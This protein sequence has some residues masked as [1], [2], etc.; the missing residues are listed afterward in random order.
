MKR[1]ERNIVKQ[2]AIYITALIV[3]CVPSLASA[4]DSN[5]LWDWNFSEGQGS[6][7]RDASAGT[8]S[9]NSSGMVARADGEYRWV[10]APQGHAMEF[11][12]ITGRL[13]IE[14]E[15]YF[16]I[17]GD[18]GMT[19]H[20][21]VRVVKSGET[22][23]I[24]Y[25]APTLELELRGENGV[26]SFNLI[27]QDGGSARCLGK[28]PISDGRWHDV[29]AIRDPQTRTLRLYV[30]G[31]LE[32][33]VEDGTAGQLLAIPRGAMLG[34]KPGD[35]EMLGGA[36]AKVAMTRGVTHISPR[37]AA[38]DEKET[39]SWTLAN[40]QVEIEFVDRNGTLAIDSLIDRNTNTQFIEKSVL[41]PNNLWQ[42]SLRSAR[43]PAILDETQGELK[44][45]QT[46]TGIVFTW[47]KLPLGDGEATVTMSVELPAG[48]VMSTWKLDV[49]HDSDEFGVWTAHSP[50]ISNLRQ[51]DE[52]PMKNFVA[53]P[54][55]NGGGA[56]E[57]QLFENPWETMHPIIR[58]YPCY[59]QSMQ[60]NAWYGPD[61]GLYLGTHD[62]DMHLKGFLIKPAATQDDTP[63]MTYEVIHY[64][65]DSGVEG[66][67][68][69][70]SYPAVV[71][72]FQGDW[73]DAS[74]IYR[75]WAVDQVWC[76]LGPA[77]QRT[78]ISPWL[79]EGAWWTVFSM[80]RTDDHRPA[81]RRKAREMPLDEM[82]RQA[83]NLDIESNIKRVERAYDYFGFPMVLWCN[84]WW[85]GGGDISPPRY[86][87]MRGLTEFLTELRSRVP[88]AHLSGHMQAKRFSVQLLEYTDEVKATIE[89]TADGN[90]AIEPMDAMDKGDQIAYPCW[91]TEFWQEDWRKRTDRIASYG[92]DG[93]HMDELG[94]H[95]DFTVQ[96]FN[97][98]HGHPVGG[99]TMYA[100]TRRNMVTIIRDEARKHQPGFA[101]HHEVL[102]EIYID[103]ADAAEVCTS[104]NN[105]N[106]PMWEAV[107]HDYY[108][109]MGRRIIEW[110][111]RNTYPIGARDGD[112]L[113][114]EFASSYAQTFI[115]GNQPSWTRIDILDYAPRV[116]AFIK[117]TMN[118]RYRTLDYLNFGDMM[119]P[120]V[121][122]TPLEK[123]TR[124]WRLNDTPEHTLPVVLNS[125]WKAPD[126]SLG[127]VLFN[128]TDQPQTID[129]R[130]DLA[131]C[132]LKG[133]RFTIT[134]I[135]GE[136]PQPMGTST[137][138]ML[139]RSDTIEPYNVMIL[140]IESEVE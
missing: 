60:F 79:M 81:L 24:V 56:G 82:Y 63:V 66:T 122:T 85:D 48:S 14:S 10:G 3:L 5:K 67:T 91:T 71:G 44:A 103:V 27:G 39:R 36:I 50:R 78:D 77:Y 29:M 114:D 131:E 133:D 130:S 7:L 64:P 74:R 13:Q 43:W 116:A 117:K 33:E 138:T 31:V 127:I 112:E 120:L 6:T 58:T 76:R 40:D 83:R 69:H 121:V 49:D 59:Y 87:P 42:V 75:E 101:L 47:S 72:V 26:V 23:L 80:D 53:I 107:Y 22:Q 17:A 108:F 68:F 102:S 139:E 20:T 16:Q 15:G 140:K 136:Q 100:D 8:P 28:T 65:P 62:G 128:I 135:D 12:G 73:Y 110:M 129:Y 46:K 92:L 118:A 37:S 38:V 119:R 93:F 111:D 9:G 134:R 52:D 90:M 11:N 94:S 113:F 25:A 132:G 84:E 34:G 109:V 97:R 19:L 88:D 99:G 105:R 86:V 126:G 106:I 89:K 96:C 98:D 18:E 95:T 123:V 45:T 2:L 70:Q 54:G 57:G 51:L 35:R 124:I 137:G 32:N 41:A 115:W 30:D 21:V 61:A 1:L 125:V 104:P 4:A 55:G